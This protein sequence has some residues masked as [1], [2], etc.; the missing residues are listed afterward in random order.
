MKFFEWIY[1][2]SAGRLRLLLVERV[3]HRQACTSSRGF[4]SEERMGEK[5]EIRTFSSESSRVT[6]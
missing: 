3:I 5:N 1:S 6:E 4:V 2:K